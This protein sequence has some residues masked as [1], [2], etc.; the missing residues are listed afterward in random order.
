MQF[1][2]SPINY[3][4]LNYFLSVASSQMPSIDFIPVA[5]HIYKKKGTAFISFA[6]NCLPINFQ[7]IVALL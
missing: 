2:P 4:F 1:P 5:F 6:V 3:L 7:F